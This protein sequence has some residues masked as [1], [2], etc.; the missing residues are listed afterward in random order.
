[1]FLHANRSGFLNTELV[2]N[3]FVK[4]ADPAYSNL[5]GELIFKRGDVDKTIE[6][7]IIQ[8]PAECETSIFTVILSLPKLINNEEQESPVR[9]KPKLGKHPVCA[10]S[11]V[12]DVERPTASLP[13]EK[14]TIR[15]SEKLFSIGVVRGGLGECLVA[16]KIINVARDNSPYANLSGQAKFTG[17]DQFF[18]V[19]FDLP[20]EPQDV[21]EDNFQI[22][23]LDPKGQNNPMLGAIHAAE[24]TVINDIIVDFAYN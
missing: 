18:T 22:Q 14:L 10:V 23:L 21:A 8:T 17:E 4:T 19:Q 9:R 24:V 1:M 20:Q 12:N 15:Q 7:D 11:I 2:S 5:K 6:L 13:V 16:W 3:W